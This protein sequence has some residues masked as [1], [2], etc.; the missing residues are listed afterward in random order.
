MKLRILLLTCCVLLTSGSMFAQ[1]SGASADPISG[2]WGANGVTFLELEF[3]GKAAVSG[4]VIW[5]ESPNR[6]TRAA[7]K[8]GTFDTKTGALKLEGAAKGRD[9]AMA[10]YVIEGKLDNDTLTGSFTF[11]DDKG[12]FKFTRK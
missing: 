3:D 8:S 12:T 5:R 10:E 2:T 7:I 6:E 4:T 1:S 9:G 11:G